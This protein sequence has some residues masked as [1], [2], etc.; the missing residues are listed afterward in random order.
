MLIEQLLWI[1]V[2]ILLYMG[3]YT[4]ILESGSFWWYAWDCILSR[5]FDSGRIFLFQILIGRRLEHWQDLKFP[6]ILFQEIF[7]SQSWAR[8]M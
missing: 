1:I 8:G 4:H 2:V 5:V 6:N 3:S 7:Y